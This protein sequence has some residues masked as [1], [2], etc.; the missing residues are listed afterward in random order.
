M[1]LFELLIAFAVFG[2]PAWA[3]LGLAVWFEKRA[4]KRARKEANNVYSKGV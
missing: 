3:L 2:L 4:Q 1:L